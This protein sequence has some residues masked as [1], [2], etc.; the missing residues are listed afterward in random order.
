MN[1]TEGRTT[2]RLYGA[3]PTNRDG[4]QNALPVN[5]PD[6]APRDDNGDPIFEVVN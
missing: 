6:D 5:P 4:L 2:H 1:D 3:D